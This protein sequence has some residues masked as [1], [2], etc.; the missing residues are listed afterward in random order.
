MTSVPSCM[1]HIH[2][3]LSNTYSPFAKGPNKL[4]STDISNHSNITTV[5][6]YE[7]VGRKVALCVC[8]CVECVRACG[9]MQNLNDTARTFV[10][11]ECKPFEYR[12]N[13]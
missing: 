5:E 10:L 2:K 11:K 13:V 9:G 6:L 4:L 8:V 12:G 3:Y 1:T 7:A